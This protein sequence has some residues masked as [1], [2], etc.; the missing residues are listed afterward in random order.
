MTALAVIGLIAV[1]GALAVVTL[2]YVEGRSPGGF[3]PE[4]SSRSAWARWPAFAVARSTS[5]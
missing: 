4:S 3:T 5:A 1:H 2:Y